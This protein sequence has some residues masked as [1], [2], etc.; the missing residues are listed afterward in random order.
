MIIAD[1]VQQLVNSKDINTYNSLLKNGITKGVV[2]YKLTDHGSAGFMD[3]IN[4][5]SD[6]SK[7]IPL[8]KLKIDILITGKDE[9]GEIIWN[10]SKSLRSLKNYYPLKNVLT[11]LE[12]DDIMKQLTKRGLHIYRNTPN[13][14]GHSNDLPSY[15]GLGFNTVF[16]MKENISEVE[17]E[18]YVDKH[19]NCCGFY[20]GEYCV[21]R[22]C[23]KRKGKTKD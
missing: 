2:S 5:I 21:M 20:N 8:R 10:E 9:N 16:E 11:K 23:D 14:Q 17:Y 18:N 3:I 4:L 12:W 15:W 22:R 1:L 6:A 7:D 13:R 19:Y